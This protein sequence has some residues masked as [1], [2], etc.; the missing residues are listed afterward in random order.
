MPTPSMSMQRI[1]RYS[2]F[3]A[4]QLRKVKQRGGNPVMAIT[5]QWC[6]LPCRS[7]EHDE[8]QER[9]HHLHPRGTVGGTA[10]EEEGTGPC[11]AALSIHVTHHHHP[12]QWN[13]IGFWLTSPIHPLP[14]TMKPPLSPTKAVPTFQEGK[15]LGANSLAEPGRAQCSESWA[16]AVGRMRK[17]FLHFH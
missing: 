2:N 11:V 17:I 12:T 3:S 13:V 14:R 10:R 15:G 5:G 8:E 4:V 7:C 6:D 9:Y 16:G 1:D